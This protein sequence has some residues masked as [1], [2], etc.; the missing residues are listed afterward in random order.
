MQVNSELNNFKV[1]TKFSGYH[2]CTKIMFEL[3]NHAM[4]YT[5]N[6]HTRH[7]L[8]SVYVAFC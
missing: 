4:L 2:N 6:L 1:Q 5:Y 8:H 3:F 7:Q